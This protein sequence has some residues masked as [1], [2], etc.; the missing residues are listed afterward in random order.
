MRAL[1][2]LARTADGERVLGHDL[3]DR[4]GLPANYL[5]KILVSLSRAGLVEACR[6]T[7]GGYRLRREPDGVTLLE[8]V[9][10]LEGPQS[11]PMCL[12]RPGHACS[13][14]DPCSAHQE[15]AHLREHYLGYL[16]G[17]SIG[18]LAGSPTAPG[19]SV[20]QAGIEPRAMPEEDRD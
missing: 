7:G 19:R 8:I 9:E 5:S 15:W 18:G 4:A 13:T 12:L 16:A 2:E 20:A 10:L 3:A 11:E 14:E 6:G 1:I 17:T